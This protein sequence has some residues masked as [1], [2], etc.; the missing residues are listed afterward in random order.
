MSQRSNSIGAHSYDSIGDPWWYCREHDQWW[1]DYCPGCHPKLDR[2]VRIGAAIT[3]ALIVSAGIY[4]AHAFWTTP[5][6]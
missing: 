2:A 3:A 6:P 4:V 5:L 1:S